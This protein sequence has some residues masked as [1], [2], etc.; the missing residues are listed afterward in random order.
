[1]ADIPSE[2]LEAAAVDT[3]NLPPTQYLV[4]EVL[5]ARHRLGE[6]LWTFPSRPAIRVAADQLASL[7]LI[8]WKG[9]VEP[10]T[11]RAWLTDAGR[12]AALMEG[13]E[14]PDFKRGVAAGRAQAAAALRAEIDATRY[15]DIPL[16][17]RALMAAWGLLLRLN[18]R[19]WR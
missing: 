13:Y 7:G 4:L 17:Q 11:I 12:A 18:P 15:D 8:G 2:A 10:K 1:M 6:Q 5:A 9:G 3:D 19:G 14:S 16:L